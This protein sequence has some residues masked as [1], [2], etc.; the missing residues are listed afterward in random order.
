MRLRELVRDRRF[1]AFLDEM[2]LFTNEQDIQLNVVSTDQPLSKRFFEW[3]G[4]EIDGLLPG[5]VPRL[6]FRNGDVSAW[7]AARSSR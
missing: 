7:A 6:P 5:R 2:E 3:L 1:P 4:R